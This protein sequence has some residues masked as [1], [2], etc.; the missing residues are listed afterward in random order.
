MEM[1]EYLMK[2]GLSEK[3]SKIYLSSL[4]IGAASVQHIA[5]QAN[6]NRATA[7]ANID[8]LMRYGYMSAFQEGKKQFFYSED[9]EKIIKFLL[10]KKQFE[11]ENQKNNIKR[12]IPSLKAYAVKKSNTPIVSYYHGTDGVKTV[13]KQI[14]KGPED[15]YRII[16]NRDKFFSNFK[17]TELNK[18][19]DER[20]NKNIK[21]KILRISEE[22]INDLQDADVVNIHPSE[23]TVDFDFSIYNKFIRMIP[24]KGELSAITIYNKNISNTFK[25]VF[26]LVSEIAEKRS[27]EE[28]RKD[29]YHHHKV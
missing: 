23:L 14:F 22:N 10:R 21:A 24:L 13:T 5:K 3:E 1:H 8:N 7:Y 29:K 28:S 19:G 20:H 9:P 4:E 6:I 17:Q 2:L 16:F 25:L 18:L 11:I 27:K 26:D 15:T 12:L